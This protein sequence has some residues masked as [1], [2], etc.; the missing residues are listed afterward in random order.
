M[1]LLKSKTPIT[2]TRRGCALASGRTA[3]AVPV[4]AAAVVLVAP[5]LLWASF[6]DG[7]IVRALEIAVA[8][9]MISW[10]I[11]RRAEDRDAALARVPGNARRDRVPAP[12]GCR[13]E[14]RR[15]QEPMRLRR[16]VRCA[17]TQAPLARR[18]VRR[19][20]RP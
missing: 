13:L 20:S 4:V 14:R 16:D 18:P 2:R 15:A 17:K 19:R 11:A 3:F 6:G 7:N 12:D 10:A 8:A 5:I 9:A 1:A